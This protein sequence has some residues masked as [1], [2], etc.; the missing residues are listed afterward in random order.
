V[1]F[2]AGLRDWYRHARAN[3]HGRRS[4]KTAGAA[5]PTNAPG[6]SAG[7]FYSPNVD[8]GEIVAARQRLWPAVPNVPAVDFREA[9]QR[10]FLQGPFARFAPD[11][12]DFITTQSRGPE[13]FSEP[14]DYFQG[15]DS[16]LLYVM[17]RWLQP[18]SIVEIGSGWSTRL[19]VA[20]IRQHLASTNTRLTTVDPYAAAELELLI[21]DL[22]ALVRS[23]AQEVPE[24][25]YRRLG[26]DDVLFIDSSHVVKTGSDVHHL[27]TQVLPLLKAGV[28]VHFHDLFLPFEYPEAWVVNDRRDWNEQYV[29]QTLLAAPSRYEI[30]IG[31]RYAT[32]ALKSEIDTA[33]GEPAP[34]GSSLWLRVVGEPVEPG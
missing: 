10:D 12:A 6:F 24:S 32:W 27:V 14:N 23:P 7:H 9:E 31:S 20:T 8:P 1:I 3:I 33:L 26:R 11:Y 5:E 18:V 21:E 25:T 16:R 17:L 15:L 28:V 13:P 4:P 19:M 30:M 22:G 29:V 2:P 34:S